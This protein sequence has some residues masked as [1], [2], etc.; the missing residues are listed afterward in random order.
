M[1]HVIRKKNVTSW[2]AG[3]AIDAGIIVICSADNTV[4]KGSSSNVAGTVGVS[5]EAVDA[6]GD[7]VPVAGIGDI[8]W[9]KAGAAV[10]RNA[11]IICGD[12][13]GR[14]IVCPASAGL[15]N[16]VGRAV[17]AVSNA[18]EFFPMLVSIYT[19]RNV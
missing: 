18:D 9:V 10:T 11:E 17:G 1:S 15:Y 8:V 19:R 6:A 13:S 12:S 3:A 14:G 5:T 16:V 7:H 4:V 2:L